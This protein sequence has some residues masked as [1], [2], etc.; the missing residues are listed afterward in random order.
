M[1]LYYIQYI[2]LL[3]LLCTLNDTSASHYFSSPTALTVG[4]VATNCNDNGSNSVNQPAPA[5]K[6]VHTTHIYIY[7][8]FYIS[9]KS[10]AYATKVAFKSFQ[11]CETF[12]CCGFFDS[13][14]QKVNKS[15]IF[16]LIFLSILFDFFRGFIFTTLCQNVFYIIFLICQEYTKEKEETKKYVH[17]TLFVERQEQAKQSR[18]SCAERIRRISEVLSTNYN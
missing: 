11:I 16:F 5:Q 10:L 1:V 17:E 4:K 6:T 7:I 2:F 12:S 9:F 14:F 3:P 15:I 13:F 18:L 8:F